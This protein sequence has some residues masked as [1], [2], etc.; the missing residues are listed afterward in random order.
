MKSTNIAV[1][2]LGH[3]LLVF[4]YTAGVAWL[5]FHGEQLF[6]R[7]HNFWAPVGLLLLFVL[8][9]NIVGTLVLGRPVLLYFN[10]KKTEALRF[11]GYT[12]AWIFVITVIVFVVHFWK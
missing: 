6:G 8:S 2:S 4:L 12:I 9:A 5:L 7:V 10:D 3:A 1:H 11:F